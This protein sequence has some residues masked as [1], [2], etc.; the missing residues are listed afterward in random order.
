MDLVPPN[1]SNEQ[2]QDAIISVTR[3]VACSPLLF[4]QGVRYAGSNAYAVLPERLAEEM[5]YAP[6]SGGE[7]GA[8]LLYQVSD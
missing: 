2:V 5:N 7:D 6:A 3:A 1:A 8:F 4:N